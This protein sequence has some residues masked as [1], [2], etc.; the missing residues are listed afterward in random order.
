MKLSQAAQILNISKPE[1]DIEFSSISSDTRTLQ[2][3]DVYIAFVG[4]QFDGHDFIA[5]AEKQQAGAVIA[6]K[7]V[8]TTLPVL[9]VDDTRQA[10]IQLAAAHRDQMT[11]KVIAVTGSCGKTTTRALLQNVFSEA[12]L[13]HASVASFNNEIGVSHTLLQLQPQHQ[14]L[15]SEIGTNAPGEIKTLVD[16]VQPDL[17]IITNVTTAHLQFFKDLQ[18][19]AKEKGDIIDGVT[20]EGMVV[21][22]ADDPFFN[23]W[24]KRAR[25]RRV[26]SFAM[27]TDADLRATDVVL[28]EQGHPSFNIKGLGVHVT[29]QLVGKHNVANALA[30][31]AAGMAMGL[32]V[33]QIK[34]GLEK[35]LP[36]AKRMVMQRGY[37]NALII[38]DA[39][40]ANPSSTRAAIDALSVLRGKR[41]LVFADMGELGEQKEQ[42]H[43]QIGEYASKHQVDRL[44]TF[45]ELA[46]LTAEA[47]GSSSQHFTDLQQLID[48]VKKNCGEDSNILI[49]GSRSMKMER[50]AQALMES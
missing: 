37:K 24:K 41:W 4:D 48:T 28:D 7:M 29:L 13:T 35:T 17:A 23:E 5:A 45:G 40:N 32:T 21:L 12:G 14:Y 8:D 20:E 46:A 19:Y 27:H 47:F 25:Q 38:N 9:I 30:A 42:L 22:N 36:E 18:H 6:N 11:A 2:P 10:Y 1:C 16:V 31:A 43:K 50:V 34:A 33:S 15:I 39:Y 26:I 3:G 49:K 44:F